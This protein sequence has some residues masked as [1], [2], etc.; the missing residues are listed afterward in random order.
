MCVFIGKSC[1]QT[2]L[3]CSCHQQYR[4]IPP[5]F[6]SAVRRN[7]STLVLCARQLAGRIWIDTHMKKIKW[8]LH[9]IFTYSPS[10]SSG[11]SF[12]LH[13]WTK[14]LSSGWNEQLLRL[15]FTLRYWALSL[16]A[17]V[18]SACSALVK[19]LVGNFYFII[20]NK[21]IKFLYPPSE[22]RSNIQYIYLYCKI[23]RN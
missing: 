2:A 5:W 23:I 6:L 3:P 20:N 21:I 22:P 9:V 10:H 7:L 19:A 17:H 12:Y 13:R 15:M 4:C 14:S 18:S 11:K 1:L 16:T 8:Y